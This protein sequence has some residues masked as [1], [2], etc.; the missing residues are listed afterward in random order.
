M[1]ESP[2]SDDVTVHQSPGSEDIGVNQ[3]SPQ[4]MSKKTSV[5]KRLK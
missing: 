5:W 1:N 2:C 3:S 4:K